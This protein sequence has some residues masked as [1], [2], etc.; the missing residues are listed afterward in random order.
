MLNRRPFSFSFSETKAP[1]PSDI[2]GLPIFP[3]VTRFSSIPP[4]V[5]IATTL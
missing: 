3:S 4:L 1:P 2:D 5:A